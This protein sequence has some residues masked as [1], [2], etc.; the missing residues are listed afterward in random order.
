M[1]QLSE[2][3]KMRMK[4]YRCKMTAAQAEQLPGWH[5]ARHPN[6]CGSFTC[7]EKRDSSGQVIKRRHNNRLER[8]T[9]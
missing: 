5:I 4:H 9:L 3:A 8:I 6:E 1:K 2:H 7:L